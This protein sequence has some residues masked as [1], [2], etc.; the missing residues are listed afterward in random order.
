MP[1]VLALP[2][3]CGAACTELALD[4]SPPADGSTSK[5]SSAGSFPLDIVS[6]VAGCVDSGGV[7]LAGIGAKHP[8]RHT[9]TRATAPVPAARAYPHSAGRIPIRNAALPN[10]APTP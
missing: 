10:H 3:A 8:S 5:L 6:P 4:P 7:S 2:F 9:H 1:R